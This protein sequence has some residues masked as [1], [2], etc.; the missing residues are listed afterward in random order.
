[1]AARRARGFEVAATDQIEMPA[2][3]SL[4]ISKGVAHGFLAL[5]PLALLYFVTEEYDGTDEHGFAWNDPHANLEWPIDDP[6][7]SDRDRSNPSLMDAVAAARQRGVLTV[8]R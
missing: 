5:E 7:V 2:G 6:I 1:M 8:D 4:L 3:S